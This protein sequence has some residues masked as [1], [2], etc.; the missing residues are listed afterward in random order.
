MFF[1]NIETSHGPNPSDPR[2]CGRYR[3]LRGSHRPGPWGDNGD[4]F[5]EVE[6]D[7]FD[8]FYHENR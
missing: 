8:G 7:H 4:G 6:R 1:F 3:G 2:C 5:I